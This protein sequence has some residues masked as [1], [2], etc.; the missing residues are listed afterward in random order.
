MQTTLTTELKQL[1]EAKTSLHE[2]KLS[3]LNLKLVFGFF[4]LYNAD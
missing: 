1:K 4:P 2:V 3:T